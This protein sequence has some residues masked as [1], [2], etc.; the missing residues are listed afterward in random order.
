MVILW[1]FQN[2]FSYI[3]SSLKCK[4]CEQLNK[5]IPVAF[6][7]AFGPYND[8]NNIHKA[9]H[10]IYHLFLASGDLNTNVSIENS[11][12][13]SY[14]CLRSQHFLYIYHNIGVDVKNYI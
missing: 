5:I 2:N 10:F 9:T 4:I 7:L 6:A 13:E 14:I 11:T 12:Y 8:H 1:I 3:F